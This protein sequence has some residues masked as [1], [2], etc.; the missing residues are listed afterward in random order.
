M[1]ILASGVQRTEAEK[2]F[3]VIRNVD[4]DSITTGMGVRYV[5]GVPAEDVSADG[6]QCTKVTAALDPQFLQFAG[7]A[8]SDIPADGYGLVQNFGIVDNVAISNVGT[9]ITVG[10]FGG[11]NSTL[12]KVGAAAGTFFSGGV[13]SWTSIVPVVPNYNTLQVWAT[14]NISNVGNVKGF[15]RVL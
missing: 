13:A 9:S 5:G 4:A 1:K 2:V 7:I 15:V 8:E 11:V 3:T 14:A 12:L 6:I 10:T